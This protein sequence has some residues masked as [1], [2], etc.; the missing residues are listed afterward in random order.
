M[1]KAGFRPH[2]CPSPRADVA[3]AAD[4]HDLAAGDLDGPACDIHPTAGDVDVAPVIVNDDNN[5]SR[6]NDDDVLN[7]HTAVHDS[8]LMNVRTAGGVQ[9]V[10]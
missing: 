7:N 10:E 6:A 1:G 2:R 5:D 3:G 4:N 9:I 8:E